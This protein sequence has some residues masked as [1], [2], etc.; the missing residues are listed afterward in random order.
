[1]LQALLLTIKQELAGSKLLG[2][3]RLLPDF[4]LLARKL[5]K[6]GFIYHRG[7]VMIVPEVES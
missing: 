7:G 4:M 5:E 1:M 3:H 6:L 2:W